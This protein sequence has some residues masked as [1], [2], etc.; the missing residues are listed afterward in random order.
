MNIQIF[1]TK[2]SADAHRTERK[3]SNGGLSA[4]CVEEV[5]VINQL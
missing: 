2:K 5:G 3:E 1:G 4:G